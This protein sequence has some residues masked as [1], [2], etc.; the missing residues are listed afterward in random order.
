MAF[1]WGSGGYDEGTTVEI[2]TDRLEIA[3]V[4][5]PHA[6]FGSSEGHCAVGDHIMVDVTPGD[7]LEVWAD[8]ID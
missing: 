4:E 2:S 6:N 1:P 5:S 8:P 7:E 3:G